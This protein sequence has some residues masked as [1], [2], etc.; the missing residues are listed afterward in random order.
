MTDIS[1]NKLSVYLI[2]EE[3]PEHKDILKKFDTL[4]SKNINGVGVLYFGES[5]IFKPSWLEKFFGSALGDDTKNYLM[6]A[7]KPFY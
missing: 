3:Y 1:T 4:Q 2:K 7:L 6:P 5:H